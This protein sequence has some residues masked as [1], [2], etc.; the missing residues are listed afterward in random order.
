[1]LATCAAEDS[2]G[3]QVNGVLLLAPSSLHRDVFF[4]WQVFQP[5]G[6]L[7]V[8]M[9]PTKLHLEDDETVVRSAIGV[10]DRLGQQHVLPISP[11]TE[12]IVQRLPAPRLMIHPGRLLP[13]Q[14]A[15][16]D[17][18][19]E[20]VFSAGPLEKKAI[21]VA[22]GDSVRTQHSPPGSTICPEADIEVTKVN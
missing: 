20:M 10:V 9:Q 21:V 8:E 17:V 22:A 4:C 3:G 15:E 12:N 2:Q 16:E 6:Q 1:M 5:L 7:V 14:Q 18:G 13:R 19:Q 11:P